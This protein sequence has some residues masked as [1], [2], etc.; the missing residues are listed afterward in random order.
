MMPCDLRQFPFAPMEAAKDGFEDENDVVDMSEVC[1]N[2]SISN[3]LA[4]TLSEDQRSCAD[5]LLHRLSEHGF[6]YVR[7]TGITA[8]LCEEALSLTKAFLTDA[9]ETVRR[10]CLTQDR[11]RRGYSPMCTE[12]FASLIG[13]EG[14]NDLVRKFRMG[15]T[16]SQGQGDEDDEDKFSSLLQPNIWPSE[17]TWDKELALSF[18]STMERYYQVACEA[19]NCIV[20]AISDAI[21]RKQP[22]LS[23][24]ME[25]LSPNSDT[26]AQT[27]ILTLLGYKVGARHKSKNRS[28]LV[29]AH[30]DVGVI[31]MLLFDGPGC[32]QLQRSDKKQGG[33]V[34]VRLQCA[35][36]KDPVFV[37]NIGD[38]MS[39]LTSN[40]LPSTLHRVVAEPKCKDP[41]H[42]LALFMGLDPHALLIIDNESMSYKEW[43]KRR[44]ARAQEVLSAGH[45]S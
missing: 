45:Y 8:E 37:I 43:R 26:P 18:Q 5:E 44:I 28:P 6:A 22:D 32:A 9:D 16:S 20:V 4:S 38:C 35:V 27:S 2:I 7:G 41:R 15:P 25:V 17:E 42:C 29:A 33:W 12:N 3:G 10:S 14:P 1:R 13:Q 19:A 40:I 34:P 24:A 36:P 39:E 31:T 11:A 21:R 23:K 30:T